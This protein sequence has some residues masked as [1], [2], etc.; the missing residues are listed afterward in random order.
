MKNLLFIL[1]LFVLSA[2]CSDSD[3]NALE[4][5]PFLPVTGLDIPKRSF[6]DVEI[7]MKGQGF[8][9]ECEIW[10]QINGGSAVKAEVVSVDD[11]GLTFKTS[12]NDPGF[13][14]I[15][16]KQVGKEYRIG[17]IKFDVNELAPQDIEAYGVYGEMEPTI[18]P[19]SITKH[20]VGK[21]LFKAREGYYWGGALSSPDGKIYYSGYMPDYVSVPGKPS[22]LV[23]KYYIDMYDLST[24]QIKPIE[25]THSDQ[26]SAMGLID[27]ELH[28]VVTEDNNIFR[29]V[30]LADDGTETEIKAFDLSSL[31]GKK[32]IVDNGVFVYDEA[33]KNILLTTRTLLGSSLDHYALALNVE[34]GEAK[35]NGN[36]TTVA[37]WLVNG[38]EA[39][40][41]FVREGDETF[42]TQVLKLKNPADWSYSD[43]SLKVASLAG[44]SFDFPVYSA[45]TNL[46]YGIGEDETVLIFN[47]VTNSLG[48]KW[49]K[50][51]LL[52]IFVVE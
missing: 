35:V 2:S 23:L 12:V 48:N 46:I 6:V 7:T 16:L 17:G 39:F 49:V 36:N 34:T 25:W 42:S 47:P 8:E 50:S 45:K 19:V 3:D 22:M 20:V 1:F 26:Y 43:A 10:L 18:C 38:G 52:Y 21:P 24:S 31:G 44:L 4:K 11:K 28:V 9:K 14:V 5:D 27:G 41:S 29:L 32:M 37:Y 51:G 13:Y 30:K 40:Y 33:G 15:I